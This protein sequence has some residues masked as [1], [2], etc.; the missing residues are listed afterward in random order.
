[1]V[2]FVAIRYILWIIWY[3][4]HVLEC[5][6]EKN[7][8]T[9]PRSTASCDEWKSVA[10]EWRKRAFSFLFTPRQKSLRGGAQRFL[11][12]VKLPNEQMPTARMSK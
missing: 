12:T 1:L 2:N 3:I 9:L 11:S 6:T 4:F 10:Y 7:L 8:A 5:C